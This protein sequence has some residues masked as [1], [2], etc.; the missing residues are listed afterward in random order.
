MINKNPGRPDNISHDEMNALVIGARLCGHDDI[1][2]EVLENAIA[3]R[4]LLSNT[5]KWYWDADDR[6][7]PWQR[8]IYFLCSNKYFCPLEE[9]LAYVM[10]TALDALFGDSNGRRLTWLSL[11]AVAKKTVFTALVGKFWAW[12]LSKTYGSAERL[13]VVYYND[14]RNV[15]ARYAQNLKGDP[16]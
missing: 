1:V 4:W 5:G 16:I 2:D 3:G 13:L 7:K 9:H 14:E 6:L 15:L 11:V 8:A 10:S 12:R